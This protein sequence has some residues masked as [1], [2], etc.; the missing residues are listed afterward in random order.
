MK[1]SLS[2]EERKVLDQRI[3]E[4][5]KRTGAQVVLA[6]I[7]KSD[8]YAE[9]P[10]K[11]FA[12]GASLAGLLVLLMNIKGPLASSVQAALLAIVLTLAAGAG[13]AL[14]AVFVPDFARLFLFTHRAEMET[15]QYAE[16]LFLS[17]EL[18]ATRDRRAV[19]LM[20]SLF[21]RRIVVLPDK[22][23]AGEFGEEAIHRVIDSMRPDLTAGRTGQ[24][25]V[26]G[27]KS[28]EE[29]ISTTGKSGCPENSLPDDVI[30]E[31][32]T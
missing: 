6:V 20:V 27:L 31:K 12:L 4:A 14:L 32:G 9:I 28:L 24:A 1:H 25:L 30:E 29:N 10:W 5:E 26:A 11:A 8:A 16:S 21:E 2:D 19:L 23:L 13:F 7:G 3:A 17:R 22:G 18:F 15:K